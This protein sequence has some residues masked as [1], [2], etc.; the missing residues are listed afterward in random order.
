YPVA[1]DLTGLASKAER[2]VVVRVVS[3]TGG[4]DPVGLPATVYRL[5][6]ERVLKGSAGRRL[7]IKQL[8][9]P[10]P[11]PDAATGVVTFPVD[12]MPVYEPGRRYLLFLNGTS[13]IGFTSPVGLTMGAF[14]I[15]PGELAVNGFRNAGLG[16]PSHGPLPLAGLVRETRRRVRR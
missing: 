1:L 16:L 7:V 5:R 9:V 11:V 4:R 10:E 12:G 13:S 14:E 3:R 6:V 15:L 2:I 8:G